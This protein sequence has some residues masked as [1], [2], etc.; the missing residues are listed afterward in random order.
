M[1]NLEKEIEF[2][3]YQQE[4]LKWGFDKYVNNYHHSI[5]WITTVAIGIAAILISLGKPKQIWIALAFYLITT[6][7]K[8]MSFAIN[9]NKVKK[10]LMN[11]DESINK[12]Y[13]KLK[14][15]TKELRKEIDLKCPI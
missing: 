1:K 7:L 11:F 10:T 14:V 9:S 4:S 6:T 12:R 3:R 8:L 5:I 15:N 2:L 13:S